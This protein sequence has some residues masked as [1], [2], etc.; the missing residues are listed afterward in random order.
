LEPDKDHI[1]RGLFVL[2]TQKE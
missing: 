2:F 1:Y